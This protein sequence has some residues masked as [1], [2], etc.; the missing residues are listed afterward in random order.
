M[1]VQRTRECQPIRWGQGESATCARPLFPVVRPPSGRAVRKHDRPWAVR[2][3]GDRAPPFPRAPSD[4]ERP[5]R[6]Q[7]EVRADVVELPRRMSCSGRRGLAPTSPCGSW[8]SRRPLG[9]LARDVSIQASR[10]GAARRW[11]RRMGRAVEGSSGYNA[12]EV[13][14]R[15][16]HMRE[17]PRR[18]EGGPWRS[19]MRTPPQGGHAQ[20]R[21][22]WLGSFAD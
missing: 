18:D 9:A 4:F 7:A 20:R 2:P 11:A 21:A 1:G 19:S 14:W 3:P 8:A 22:Q 16:Y 17:R 13:Q 5:G 15:L 10:P 12:L 6:G